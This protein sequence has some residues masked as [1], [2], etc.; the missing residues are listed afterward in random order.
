MIYLILF[1]LILLVVYISFCY[2]SEYLIKIELQ[3]KV[4][5]RISETKTYKTIT[6]R[7]KSFDYEFPL[8]P[9]L[10]EFWIRF[11]AK[12]LDYSIYLGVLYLIDNF[13]KGLYISPFVL[14]FLALFLISPIFETLYGKTFGKFILR[15]RVMD[16]FGENPSF[17]MSY[18]KNSLQLFAIIFFI[19]SNE[20]LSE[21]DTFFF[22]NKK[23]FTY[24][25]WNKDKKNILTQL[26]KVKY[27]NLS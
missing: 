13:L 20:T 24:T 15:L 22:H 3:K 2:L 6:R 11:F 19:I 10:D 12:I 23:T 5:K 17:L 8:N 1:Y 9:N 7:G 18:I 16:D 14:A 27:S 26:K 4:T 21:D 25:I